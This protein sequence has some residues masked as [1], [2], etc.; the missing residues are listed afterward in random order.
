[1]RT[2]H[3]LRYPIEPQEVASRNTD[4]VS[5]TLVHR[6]GRSETALQRTDNADILSW[7]FPTKICTHMVVT[8]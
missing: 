6:V 4:Q 8:L 7:K 2:V 1:M 3:T 5:P